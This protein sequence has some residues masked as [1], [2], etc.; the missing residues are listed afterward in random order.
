MSNNP[1]YI[2]GVD[3]ACTRCNGPAS[4]SEVGD[5]VTRVA[6]D[7]CACVVSGADAYDMYKDLLAQLEAQYNARLRRSPGIGPLGQ[8]GAGTEMLKVADQQWPFLLVAIT[9]SGHGSKPG[10]PIVDVAV[11]RT[12]ADHVAVRLIDP[13]PGC[14][15]RHRHNLPVDAQPGHTEPRVSHCGG[16][17]PKPGYGPRP[18][19]YQI[20]LI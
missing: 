5:A 2:D 9:R 20:R 17:K 7:R 11:D 3:F 16:Y 12:Y 10:I 13:C 8:M 19:E 18:D 14:G 1:R 6:C 15:Y 4:T